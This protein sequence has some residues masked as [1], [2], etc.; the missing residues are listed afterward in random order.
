MQV[1]KCS[2]S[3]RASSFKPQCSQR[4][5]RSMHSSALCRAKARRSISWPHIS[6]FGSCMSQRTKARGQMASCSAF[7]HN[8]YTSLHSGQCCGRRGQVSAPCF[9]M[10]R[11]RTDSPHSMHRTRRNAH[12]G[13]CAL[14]T[15]PFH[16]QPRDLCGQSLNDSMPSLRRAKNLTGGAEATPLTKMHAWV[17]CIYAHARSDHV[18][19]I[20]FT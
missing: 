4:T 18:S 13:K 17:I 1:L 11:L 10:S 15:A 12:S 19:L 3:R 7:S 2:S 5:A 6:P 20:Y 9:V 8:T 14:T 16:V